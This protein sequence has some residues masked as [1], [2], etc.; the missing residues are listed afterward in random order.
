MRRLSI[1]ILSLGIVAG[2][3]DANMSQWSALGSRFK[4][5][6][7]SGGQ[8]VRTYTSTGKVATEAQSDGW[9]FT[10]S[11]TKGLIRVSGTVTIEEI[12]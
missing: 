9:Y 6:V 10:D 1:L 8:V 11:E 5:T 3:T 4:V 2:C 12:K 7:Y